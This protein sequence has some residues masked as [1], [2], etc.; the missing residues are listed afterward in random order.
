MNQFISQIQLAHPAW[1][2]LLLLMP[3]LWLRLRKISLGALL[4]RSIVLA[5]LALALAGPERVTQASRQGE[6]LFA[7]DLS[8]SIPES[9]KSWMAQQASRLQPADRVLVF[10][11]AVEEVEDWGRWL[12]G[13]GATDRVKPE[14]TNLEALFSALLRL[15]PAPL[16]VYLFTD[17]WETEGAAERLLPSLGRSGIRVYPMAP[18]GR[19]EFPG[20]AVARIIAPHYGLKGESATLK[21]VVENY[22]SGDVEGRL[23]LRRAGQPFKDETV[24]LKPGSQLLAYQ[25]SLE[26]GPLLSL[27][28]EFT[29]RNAQADK[30]D[31]D[32]QATA[33][34]SVQSKGKVLLLNGQPGEGKYLEEILKRRG[35]DVTSLAPTASLPSPSSYG[36]IVFNNVP[37]EKISPSYLA[38]VER[39]VAAGNAFIILGDE[40]GLKPGGYR[41]TPV[42]SILPVEL[43]EPKQEEQSRAVILVIDKSNSMD[44]RVNPLKENRLL[45]AKETARAVIGQLGEEDFIGVIAIDTKPSTLIPLALVKLVRSTFGAEINRLAAGGNSYLLSGL[46]EAMRQLQQQAADRKHVILVTDADEI[47]GSPSEYVDLA[48]YMRKE[49][50]ITVSAVGLGRGVDEAFVKR[51]ATYGGGVS[52]VAT[53]LSKLPQIV[54]QHIAQQ[55]PEAP[56]QDKESTPQAVKGSEMLRGF[57]E[58]KFPLVGGYI[59]SDLKKGATLDLVVPHEGKGFPLLAS[60]RYGKG[61]A[62]AFTTDL[63]GR[64]SKAWIAWDGLERFLGRAFDWLRPEGETVPPHEVRV[65][66]LYAGQPVLD[67]YLYSEAADGNSIRYSFSGAGAGEGTLT[68][69]APGHYQAAL[70]F[71]TPGDYRLDLR[72]ERSGAAVPYPPVGYTLAPPP[73]AEIPRGDIDTALLA[74]IAQATGGAINPEPD[75]EVGVAEP[76]ALSPQPLHSYLISYLVILAVL[77]FLAEIFLRRF[78]EREKLRGMSAGA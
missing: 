72:E 25:A 48:G 35:F 57:S 61:K 40:Q 39:H 1:L 32:N 64:W 68:R 34:I 27:Q 13:K 14:R 4:L 20:V 19:F 26:E 56:R 75:R 12:N 37:G 76:I 24:R 67:L 8:H 23:I 42:E 71:S 41:Q 58:G 5:L 29:P 51:I 21:V 47:T 53:D 65:N 69:L 55:A 62:A 7:F 9:M 78:S 63:A 11:G 46:E 59:E 38:A 66:R 17:G 77:L 60:W 49:L 3:L 28:A 74:S 52:Y 36:V 22:N 70:P 6:R 31:G 50:K 73:K 45:Y 33:W 18:P 30:F 16:S 10:G 44:E 15:P 2:W 43:R 54:F